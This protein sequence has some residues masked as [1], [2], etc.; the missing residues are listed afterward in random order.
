MRPESFATESTK[1]I[2]G[3]LFGFVCLIWLFLLRQWMLKH[4]IIALFVLAGCASVPTPPAAPERSIIDIAVDDH[5][6]AVDAAN[7][8][9]GAGQLSIEG[10]AIITATLVE[11]LGARVQM[12]DRIRLSNTDE[13]VYWAG[14]LIVACELA[15]K[16]IE[17]EVSNA[18]NRTPAHTSGM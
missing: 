5:D 12:D 6:A 10:R 4:S 1:P 14:R 13:A 15:R 7:R 8:V 16:Q 18:H 17:H 2:D 9:F 3:N 11:A